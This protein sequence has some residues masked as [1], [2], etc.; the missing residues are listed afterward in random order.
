M[1]TL[2][3]LF[4]ALMC[5]GTAGRSQSLI[6]TL[7]K[8]RAESR[9]DRPV[10]APAGTRAVLN[11]P[12]GADPAQRFDLWLPANGR[13]APVVFYVHGGGWANGN[14]DNPGIETKLAH[15]IPKGYVVV[16]TNYR[17]VPSAGP[18]EQARD[19]ARALSTLQGR[20]RT[21]GL[22]PTRVVLMGHS[23]GAHLVALLGADPDMLRQAGALMPRGVVAL[24]SGALDVTAL[25][26]QPRVPQ[27]YKNAFGSDRRY[28]RKSAPLDQLARK[29]L[30]ILMVCSSSRQRPTSPCDEARDLHSKATAL[31]VKSYVLPVAMSHADINRKLGTPS[32]YTDAVSRRVDDWVK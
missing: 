10:V 22:D 26:T 20:A 2:F 23:A 12:Y 21:W 6:D 28:W 31:G 1:K 5:V 14:K 18:V 27:L 19:V 4:T 15:W 25:M 30:P 3:V 32:A 13:A 11:V 7:Q 24:D 16:S 29:S 8:R 9:Q 17:L